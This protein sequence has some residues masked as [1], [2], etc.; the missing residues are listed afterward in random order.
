MLG[1]RSYTGNQ[2][3]NSSPR[4]HWLFGH[5]NHLS[6]KHVICKW[7]GAR[8]IS[9]HLHCATTLK[10]INQLECRNQVKSHN[11]QRCLWCSIGSSKTY[12]ANKSMVWCTEEPLLSAIWYTVW[13][14]W[15]IWNL[16]HSCASKTHF[17]QLQA[18]KTGYIWS[19]YWQTDIS[20]KGTA[21]AK[22]WKKISLRQLCKYC[23]YRLHCHSKF[24]LQLC[25]SCMCHY[26]KEDFNASPKWCQGNSHCKIT[27]AK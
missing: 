5:E 2:F 11:R 15:K 27:D 14:K 1:I 9:Q 4:I 24:S 8:G 12:Q 21:A 6:Q 3:T 7:A 20:R 13:P 25:F 26:V 23:R 16:S 17:L 18:I 19:I 10:G 22:W